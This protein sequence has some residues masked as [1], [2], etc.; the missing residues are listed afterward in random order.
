MVTPYLEKYTEQFD[1][2]PEND[3]VRQDL[4]FWDV[5]FKFILNFRG[6]SFRGVS[7]QPEKS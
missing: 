5:N 2:E 3:D 7:M 6:V 4:L 1:V